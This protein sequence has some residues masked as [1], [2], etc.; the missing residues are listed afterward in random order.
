MAEKVAV[1][2]EDN[3]GPSTGRRLCVQANLTGVPAASLD[4]ELDRRARFLSEE[5]LQRGMWP[6][7]FPSMRA[8]HRYALVEPYVSD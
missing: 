6:A 1:R 2:V 5:F 8:R 3:G 4:L 7:G